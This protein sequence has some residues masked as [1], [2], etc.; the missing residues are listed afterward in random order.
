MT[1]CG[2]CLLFYTTCLSWLLAFF[3]VGDAVAGKGEQV[4]CFFPYRGD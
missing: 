2:G 4:G 3:Q 1:D